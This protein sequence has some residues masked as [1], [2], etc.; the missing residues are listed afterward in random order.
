VRLADRPDRGSDSD[1]DPAMWQVPKAIHAY[2]K[3]AKEYGHD[4]TL[5]VVC[6]ANCAES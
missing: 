5:F 3:N 6:V 1:P 4:D 2:M